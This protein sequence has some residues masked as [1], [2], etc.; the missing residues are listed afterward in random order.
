MKHWHPDSSAA[1]PLDAYPQ[2]RRKREWITLEGYV[3]PRARPRLP[4]EARL[5]GWIGLILIVLLSALVVAG[6]IALLAPPHPIDQL[7]VDP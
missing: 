4:G 1:V 7:A 6:A 2:R 5:G 3:P